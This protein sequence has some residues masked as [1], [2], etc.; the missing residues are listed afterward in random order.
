MAVL[1]CDPAKVSQRTRREGV[2]PCRVADAV[3]RADAV[4]YVVH[5]EA[6]ARRRVDRVPGLKRQVN[7][8]EVGVRERLVEGV[9]EAEAEL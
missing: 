1:A 7:V 8:A 4:R 2:T 9:E 6:L 5:R 3:R